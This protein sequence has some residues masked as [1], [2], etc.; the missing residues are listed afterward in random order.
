MST[1]LPFDPRPRPGEVD[2]VI[3]RVRRRRV[4]R[5]GSSGAVVAAGVV[6]AVLLLGTGGVQTLV[7][8]KD[9]VGPAS[10]GPTPL[11]VGPSV[12][13]PVRPTVVATSTAS[14][15]ATRVPL[16]E[17]RAT[18]TPRPADQATAAPQPKP[19]RER[20]VYAGQI[21][22]GYA[23]FEATDCLA[24][25]N[26]GDGVVRNDYCM[27]M[28]G[29]GSKDSW[30]PYIR[31]CRL[32][33]ST[34]PGRLTFPAAE[35]A[36]FALYRGTPGPEGK[37]P[38]VGA[39]VFRFSDTVRYE[40]GAHGRDVAQGACWTWRLNLPIDFESYPADAGFVGEWL[41]RA[42][43]IPAA[44]RRQRIHFTAGAFHGDDAP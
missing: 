13:A 20:P 21:G 1:E 19:A 5:A 25:R 8:D 23:E 7:Q 33:D 43:Q 2:A 35:E 42:Q 37:P 34:T 39:L 38:V 14:P 32:Y 6:G 3:G 18:P 11:A 44:E 9:P 15:T 22:P 12:A 16:I 17:P 24:Y 31:I 41:T 29:G 4:L 28:V 40:G 10:S 27:Y 26:T 36:D 30:R